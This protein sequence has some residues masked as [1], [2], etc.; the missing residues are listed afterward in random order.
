MSVTATRILQRLTAL[1]FKEL[2]IPEEEKDV[3]HILVKDSHRAIIKEDILFLRLYGTSEHAESDEQTVIFSGYR[4]EDI[5][6]IR[7][8]NDKLAVS[9]RHD[10]I[11]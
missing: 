7:I 4:F 6:N 10:W 2:P 1:G 3:L 9:I 11:I 5:E 8:I